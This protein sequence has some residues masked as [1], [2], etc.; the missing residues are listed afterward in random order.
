MLSKSTF[1]LFFFFT[2]CIL[3]SKTLEGVAVG[4]GWQAFVAY[5]NVGCYYI[6]GVPLGSLLGFYFKHGAKGIWLGLLGGTLMQTIILIVVMV[7]T[8]WNKEVSRCQD[9]QIEFLMHL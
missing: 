2:Q 9:Y 1:Y 6:V 4:C 3:I 7:R 5:V 8:D